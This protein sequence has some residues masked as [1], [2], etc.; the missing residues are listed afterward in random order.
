M[1]W[2]KAYD[3]IKPYMVRIETESGFGTGFLFA[4]TGNH[5]LAAFATACH[6]IDDVEEWKKPLRIRHYVSGKVVFFD[7]SERVILTDRRR[8]T[9]TI[10]ISASAF[11]LPPATLSLL[12]SD[13]IKKI[14]VEVGWT[15]F[16]S[17]SPADLC[18]FS[19]TV[20]FYNSDDE[21]YFIDGVAINGVSGGPVFYVLQD[22]T[23]QIVGV[24]SAYVANRRG[25][26]ALPGLLKARDLTTLHS[27]INK[28]K[29]LEEAKKKETE[30]RKQVSSEPSLPEATPQTA[31]T[32]SPPKPLAPK[33]VGDRPN[34]EEKPSAPNRRV[35]K[36]R[37]TR[38]ATKKR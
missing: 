14:G 38:K 12:P 30:L 23:P 4:Y 9:A 36:V 19:G 13:K 5:A 3:S 31:T 16:P 8:D 34:P 22:E 17:L 32:P 37:A 27:H 35:R 10:L 21:S 1:N 24:I 15:G 33:K 29:S 7:Q 20:S 25:G 18:F 28:I 11:N 2:H 26:E 6:V